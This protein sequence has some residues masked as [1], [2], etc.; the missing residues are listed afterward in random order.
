[1]PGHGQLP[2]SNQPNH[3]TNPHQSIVASAPWFITFTFLLILLLSLLCFCC[4]CVH[5]MRCT[6]VL[7][8]C[9]CCCCLC[10]LLSLVVGA[11]KKTPRP[12]STTQDAYSHTA[13]L[14]GC[15]P[16]AYHHNLTTCIAQSQGISHSAF[17]ARLNKICNT[18]NLPNDSQQMPTHH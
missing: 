18:T 8:S 7:Q 9:P 1:M 11:S 12:S 3:P 5:C 10:V 13:G 6:R 16:T 2:E 15:I 17:M 4:C 14:L